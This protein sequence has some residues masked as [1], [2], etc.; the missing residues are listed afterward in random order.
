M[1]NQRC[2]GTVDARL[3]HTQGFLLPDNELGATP[4]PSSCCLYI[5]VEAGS[6]ERTWSHMH[7]QEGDALEFKI[8]DFAESGGTA[9]LSACPCSTPKCM[10]TLQHGLGVM[11]TGGSQYSEWQSRGA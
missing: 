2:R 11:F 1:S 9:T 7:Y 3:Y 6:L 5:G 4:E 10:H 8:L